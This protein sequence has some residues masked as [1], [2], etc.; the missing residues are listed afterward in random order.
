MARGVG[1]LLG[2]SALLL[3]FLALLRFALATLLGFGLRSG[4][5]GFK[6]AAQTWPQPQKE[7]PDPDQRHGPS[8]QS[9][10]DAQRGRK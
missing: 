7:E 10:P 9:P 8:R 2:E 5:V 1:G 4:Q 6:P 3:A